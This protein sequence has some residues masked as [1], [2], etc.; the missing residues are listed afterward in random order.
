MPLGM[1]EVD[2]LDGAGKLLATQI[3]DP[4]GAIAKDDAA[5]GGVEAAPMRLTKRT[6]SERGGQRVGVPQLAALST[7]AL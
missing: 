4:L 5:A 2:D 1:V 6:L 7:A 3:P